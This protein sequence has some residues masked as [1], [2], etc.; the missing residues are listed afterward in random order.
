MADSKE[1]KDDVRSFFDR[2]EHWQGRLYSEPSNRF[3]RAV[4]RRKIYALRFVKD[5]LGSTKGC[6]LDIG[7]GS[8]AYLDELVEEGFDVYGMDFSREMLK[9]VRERLDGRARIV[10]GDIEHVPFK[11]EFFNLVLCIGV[12]GYLLAD[13][14][15][16][17]ELQRV[18]LPGGFLVVNIEN[19]MS[20]SNIDYIIRLKLRS[21]FSASARNNV[22]QLR[23]ET[24]LISP[25]VLANPAKGFRYKLYHPKKFE[26]MMS[27]AGFKLVDAMTFGFEFRLVRKFG[28]LPESL[29]TKIEILLETLLRRFRV[30]YFSYAGESYTAIFQ[31]QS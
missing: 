16:L 13:K 17:A 12:L 8:G 6:A 27:K 2:D 5:A 18:L 15:A 3:A 4:T 20:I 23:N 14:N 19:M 24:A 11:G 1:H 26:I 30:P 28:L 10:C 29:C 25:W 9:R 22:R 21:L 31:K 7:C